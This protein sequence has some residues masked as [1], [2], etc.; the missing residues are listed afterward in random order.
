MMGRDPAKSGSIPPTRSKADS[1]LE[2]A[3]EGWDTTF[4]YAFL[5][6]VKRGTVGAIIL[7]SLELMRAVVGHWLHL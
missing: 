1:L 3:K 5:L 6:L 4:R 7:T 2:A